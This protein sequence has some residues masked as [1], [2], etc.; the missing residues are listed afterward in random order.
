MITIKADQTACQGYGNCVLAFPDAFDLT[1]SGFV[2]LLTAEGSD[3]AAEKVRAAVRDCPTAAL[4]S[5]LDAG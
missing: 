2:Q 5:S 1:D 3:D 4:S